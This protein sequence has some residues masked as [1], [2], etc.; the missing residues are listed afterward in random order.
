M[1][2]LLTSLFICF[3]ITLCYAEENCKGEIVQG[4]KNGNWKCYYND[5][6]IQMEGDY[7]LDQKQGVWKIYHTNGQLAA[8]GKYQNSIEKGKWIFYDEEGKVIHENDY[9]I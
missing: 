7:M 8:L 1:R 9:G 4:K 5:G 2:N 3:N 6:K